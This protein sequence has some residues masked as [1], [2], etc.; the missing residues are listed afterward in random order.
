[1]L[2]V[3]RDEMLRL[4]R[5][6]YRTQKWLHREPP[7]A[8]ADV[9]RPYFPNVPLPL[10]GA[11]VA[12]YKALGIWGRDPFLPRQ[13]YERLRASLVSAEFAKGTPFDTAVDNS[14]AEQVID[15]DPPPL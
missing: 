10:L 8:L 4:V 13:G 1:V 5:G 14:L 12:R 15:E 7:D 3:K 2:T 6:L 11:A 9:I